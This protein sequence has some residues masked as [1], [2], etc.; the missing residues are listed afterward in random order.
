ML[1]VFVVVL[2]SSGSL[3]LHLFLDC[4]RRSRHSLTSEKVTA[5]EALVAKFGTD[6]RDVSCECSPRV[7]FGDGSVCCESG[8]TVWD[9]IK[10]S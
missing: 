10:Y 7:R 6:A 1:F 5:C 3:H 4:V 9:A 8:K 2:L